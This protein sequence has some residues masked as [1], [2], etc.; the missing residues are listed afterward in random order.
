MVAPHIRAIIEPPAEAPSLTE[1]RAFCCDLARSHYENFTVVSW[2]APR[3]MREPLSILYAYCRTVDD[4]G[5]EAPGDRLTLLKHYQDE[6]DEAF[7]GHPRH[8]VLVALQEVIQR[9]D[10]PKDPFKRLI[11][12]N[13]IDQTTKQ[14]ETFEGLLEYCACS[15]NPVGQLVLMLYG[16]RDEDRFSLSDKTCT[17]LQLA[18]FWQDVRRDRESG[19]IYIPEEDRE[20]FGVDACDL[21]ADRAG[22]RLRRLMMFEVARTRAYF[23]AGLPLLDRVKGRLRIDLALFSRG[24]LAILDELERQSF[25]PLVR[26]PTLDGRTKALLFLSTMLRPGWSRWI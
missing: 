6:L 25:D 23:A 13:R 24:G 1:A 22:D 4:L 14:Y 16:Y 15:A 11:E 21:D 20:R 12:A 8:P 18:N 2:L 17:A 5:D 9:F 26:R 3:A 7:G 19:R 10:L